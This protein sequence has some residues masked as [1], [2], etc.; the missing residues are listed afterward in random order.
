MCCLRNLTWADIHITLNKLLDFFP[1]DTW[2]PMMDGVL[3]TNDPVDA[4]NEGLFIDR[5]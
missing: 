5:E 2:A 1:L 4:L 3:V